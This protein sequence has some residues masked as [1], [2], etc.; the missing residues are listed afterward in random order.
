MGTSPGVSF[1]VVFYDGETE[2]GIGEVVVYP[3]LDF[4][5]FQ[6]ILS[7][8]IGISSNQFSTYLADSKKPRSKI[9]ITA[10]VNFAAVSRERNCFFLVVL[11]RS[12]RDR[13]K[14]YNIQNEITN[15]KMN[16]HA[17]VMLLRRDGSVSPA[18]TDFGSHMVLDRVGY[19]N[20][21]R[22]L[23]M[24]RERYLMNMGLEGLSLGKE[25]RDLNGGSLGSEGGRKAVCEECVKAK[26][27]ER[28]VGFHWCVYDAVT[29]GFR[30]PA[31]PIAR[32]VKGSD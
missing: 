19:E 1:P 27:M 10:K 4:K 21:V 17:N 8:K 23:E 7:R 9:P 31:G 12:R 11:K 29:F 24:E 5:T 20:R 15:K 13:R 18:I 16:P 32:P 28:Q 26:D 6:S 3:S 2:A 25:H 30:S 22:E 14:N